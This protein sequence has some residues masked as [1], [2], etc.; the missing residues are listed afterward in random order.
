M[1]A[2]V[3]LLAGRQMGWVWLDPVMGVVGALVIIRWACGLLRDTSKILIDRDGCRETTARIYSLIE[4]Y[5]D[6]R[7][8]DLHLWKL[9]SN[10]MASIISIVTH[11]PK[12]PG[13]YKA[14]LKDL[15]SLHHVT[16]EVHV[17]GGDPCVE[18]SC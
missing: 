7:I 4:A 9:S 6:N 11:Y 10:K 8:A 13:H 12:P 17:S 16:V 18:R 14:L 3:A 5:S 15:Q 1:L 2:I